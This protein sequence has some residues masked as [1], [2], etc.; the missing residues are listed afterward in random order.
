MEIEKIKKVIQWAM[1]WGCQ[2]CINV[3]IM[4]KN[5]NENKNQYENKYNEN[6]NKKTECKW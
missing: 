6:N 1:L 5:K 3:Y 2:N 4:M